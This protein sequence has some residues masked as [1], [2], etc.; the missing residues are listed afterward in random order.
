MF[1][2]SSDVTVYFFDYATFFLFFL[3]HSIPCAE[4]FIA[5]QYMPILVYFFFPSKPLYAKHIF[6]FCRIL[7][8]S[9][10]FLFL[11]EKRT[12]PP[13]T[14]HYTPV[15]PS[16][17]GGSV[18]IPTFHFSLNIIFVPYYFSALFYF[19]YFSAFSIFFKNIV[20]DDTKDSHLAKKSEPIRQ[21]A[22]WVRFLLNNIRAI[23]QYARR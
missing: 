3:E 7:V 14:Y 19:L 9:L 5:L 23:I 20:S 10:T 11:A 16:D 12:H 1:F 21:N 8:F 22:G 17:T 13:C 4:L 18:F 2:F 15:S 6:D